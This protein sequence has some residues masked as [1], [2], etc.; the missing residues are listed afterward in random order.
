MGTFKA[1]FLIVEAFAII[2]MYLL[3]MTDQASSSITRND[4]TI[5]KTD[6]Y[7]AQIIRIIDGDT[8]VIKA[9]FLP[10]PLKP[11]LA[12]RVFGVDTPEKSW[13]GKCKYE[14]LLGEMASQFTKSR[15]RSAK[16]RQV[17]LIKWDKF[18]GRVLGDILLD[19][20]SLRDLLIENGYAREYYGKKK[21][22][23]CDGEG[24]DRSNDIG[25]YTRD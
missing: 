8:V 6:I 11:Q 9:P 12:I 3:F 24:T 18:G 4:N 20:K 7:D 23:W 2:T 22:S 19:G 14:R 15:I 21:E 10:Y 13:R 25:Y 1:M 16:T 17:R 5:Q